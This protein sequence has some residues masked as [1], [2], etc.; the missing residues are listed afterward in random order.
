MGYVDTSYAS[1]GK[2]VK[3]V[4]VA[5]GN[6]SLAATNK[7]QWYV[8]AS[9]GQEMAKIYVEDRGAVKNAIAR[10]GERL[11]AVELTGTRLRG[12]W[13]ER[14]SKAIERNRVTRF[15][16]ARAQAVA[17]SW[18]RKEGMGYA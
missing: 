4:F 1:Q 11:S 16:K 18:R 17:E 14:M 8:S 15:V 7:Q 10:G 2:T 9:R 6:E 5:V 3:R 13:R 12:S